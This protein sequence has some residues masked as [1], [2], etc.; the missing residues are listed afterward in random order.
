MEKKQQKLQRLG[1][2][3]WNTAL[4]ILFPKTCPI[5]DK[6]LGHGEDICGECVRKIH[7]IGEPRCKKCGKQL[8]DV[9]TEYCPDCS[10]NSHVYK[11]GIAAFLYDDLISKSIYRFKYHNRR[12]YAEYYGKAISKQYGTIIKRWN[13]DVIIPVP[14]HEKKRIRRGY[15][16]A[17]LISRSLGRELHM[18]TDSSYLVRMANTKPQKEMNKAERKKNLENAFKLT[19]NVVKYNKIILVDD[20]YTTGSTIDECARTLMA[21]GAR[22]IYFVSLS[23]GAGI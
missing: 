16:Q 21:G 13:A 8:S 15:N 22:E 20:I 6:A 12:S 3:A 11:T 17:E 5:C 19:G 10:R 23:I 9:R 18:E 2:T 1:E 4:G 14:I 7:F